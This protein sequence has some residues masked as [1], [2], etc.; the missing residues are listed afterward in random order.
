MAASRDQV[1]D[2]LELSAAQEILR[3]AVRLDQ[4]DPAV[5]GLS[6][7]ALEAAASDLGVHPSAVA[8][9]LAEAATGVTGRRRPLER[10]VGPRAVVSVRVCTVP[11]ADAVRLARTLLERG[12]LLRVT[13]SG[14]LVVGRRRRD[15][16]AKARRALRSMRGAAALS[17]VQEVRAGVGSVADGTAAVCVHA[18]VSDRRTGAV[19]TGSLFGALGLLGIG[20]GAAAVGPLVLL[21]A[22]A[23]LGT[24][25][26]VAR[27]A[28]RDTVRRIATAV[29]E[30]ADAMAGGVAAASPLAALGRRRPRSRAAR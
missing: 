1:D 7:Q 30:A 13:G 2:Q 10:V 9:A 5:E 11:A 8:M 24:G 3:R 22:P 4:G 6:L 25:V 15:P 28:H 21:L 20:V 27:Q 29:D 26:A 23:A 14:A 19:I 18:D 17:K 16:A 12:H